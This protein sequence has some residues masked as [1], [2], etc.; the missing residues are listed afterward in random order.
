MTLWN[1]QSSPRLAFFRRWWGWIVTLSAALVISVMMAVWEKPEPRQAGV[2][3]ETPVVHAETVPPAEPDI[4]QI[5]PTMPPP[6]P[7]PVAAEEP[8]EAAT[9]M[10][11]APAEENLTQRI[12]ELEERI[13]VLESR[14]TN[15]QAT[16]L[17]AVL[18]K[19]RVRFDRGERA[20][21]VLAQLADLP[22]NESQQDLFKE[23]VSLNQKGVDSTPALTKQFSALA[24]QMGSVEEDASGVLGT[25]S[26]W[27]KTHIVIRKIGE[28]HTGND[29]EALVA[30]A[31]AHLKADNVALALAELNNTTEATRRFFKSWQ[32]RAE[33]REDALRA[34]EALEHTLAPKP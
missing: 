27:V 1:E 25:V 2:T 3:E 21:D 10:P 17:Y 15:S 14:E 7:A 13:R 33:Y 9:A 4:T 30:R 16:S 12:S 6:V 5:A 22:L 31:E 32:Q 29:D 20:D 18:Y 23:L 19:L 11:L 8:V 28:E 24:D 34:L 26:H